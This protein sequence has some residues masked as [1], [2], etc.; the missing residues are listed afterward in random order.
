MTFER[1][2]NQRREHYRSLRQDRR[3]RCQNSELK[4]AI[5]KL[6]IPTFDGS[7]KMIAQA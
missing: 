5:G 1:F 2:V 3:P 4:R 6:T 7:G